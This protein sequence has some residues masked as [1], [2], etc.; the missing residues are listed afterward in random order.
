MV[1]LTGELVSPLLAIFIPLLLILF[2]FHKEIANKNMKKLFYGMFYGIGTYGSLMFASYSNNPKTDL[3]AFAH[4]FA[5]LEGAMLYEALIGIVG[6]VALIGFLIKKEATGFI[7]GLVISFS[8][9]EVY[10][11]MRCVETI[12]F[13]ENILKHVCD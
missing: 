3:G 2:A 1:T 4:I 5:T 11:A 12:P 6:T 9:F 13:M 8:I 7:A 10:F